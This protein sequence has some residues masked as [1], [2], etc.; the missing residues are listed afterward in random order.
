MHILTKATL[1]RFI[2]TFVVVFGTAFLA[3]DG[4]S[5]NG[6]N[7]VANLTAA[8]L[9]AVLIALRRS[10]SVVAGDTSNDNPL[11]G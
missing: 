6:E 2:E 9:S 10:W 3:T 4:L 5:F 7:V 11:S 1:I 8:A